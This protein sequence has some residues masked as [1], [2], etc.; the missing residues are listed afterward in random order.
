[1]FNNSNIQLNNIHD[2]ELILSEHDSRSL[3]TTDFRSDELANAFRIGRKVY[4]TQKFE[5]DSISNKRQGWSEDRLLDMI[6]KLLNHFKIKGIEKLEQF[7]KHILSN[8][9]LNEI[10]S[11]IP[12]I[13][14]SKLPDGTIHLVEGNHRVAL[15]EMFFGLN[16]I[17]AFIID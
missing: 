2:V 6:N 1:M 3:S 5:L 16:K 10:E 7:N 15:A 8:D 12:P 17:R 11:H 13:I 14:V 4:F 9:V